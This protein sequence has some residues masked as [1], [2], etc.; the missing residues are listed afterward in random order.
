MITLEDKF[1]K[2]KNS[3]KYLQKFVNWEAAVKSKLELSHQP[4]GVE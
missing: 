4:S 2:D 1:I 3:L